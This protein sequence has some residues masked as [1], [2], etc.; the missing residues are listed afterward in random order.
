MTEYFT[1]VELR[2]HRIASRIRLVI[3]RVVHELVPPVFGV[4]GKTLTN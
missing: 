2:D 1:G 3:Y 4:E